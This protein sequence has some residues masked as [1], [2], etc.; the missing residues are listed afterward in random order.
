MNHPN[1]LKSS[2]LAFCPQYKLYFMQLLNRSAISIFQSV[3]LDLYFPLALFRLVTN[4]SNGTAFFHL[5]SHKTVI[6]TY[7]RVPWPRTWR[8]LY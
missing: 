1:I 5:N 7:L 8:A 3:W 4:F 6:V 2:L